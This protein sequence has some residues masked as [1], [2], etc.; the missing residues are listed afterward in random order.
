MVPKGE[1]MRKMIPSGMLL[2][3][4]FTI[5]MCAQAEERNKRVEL[6]GGASR[7][8]TKDFEITQPQS[9][10]PFPGHHEFS[11]GARGGVRLGFDGHR[12]WG[13]DYDYSYGQDASRIITTMGRFTFTNHTH[14]ASANI[15]LYPFNL[16][17]K[18]V[19]PYVTAGLGATFVTLSQRSLGQAVQGGIGPLKNETVLAFNAGGGLRFRL[20]NRFGFR[21]DARDYM[22]RALRYGLPKSSTD[23]NAKVFPVGGAFH[24]I[25]GSVALVIQF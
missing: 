11:Y 25:T 16:D 13:M 4:L 3:M 18:Y 7:P 15:L 1:P 5:G 8:L 17:R 22:S 19:F 23:P 24:Q 20:T 10:F 21:L 14:Q 6:Y 2:L 9:P 12:Y